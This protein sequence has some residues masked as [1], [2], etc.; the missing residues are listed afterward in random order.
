MAALPS[1]MNGHSHAAMNLLRGY[2]DDMALMDWL[3]NKIWPLEAKLTENDVYWGSKLAFLEMI[4]S[5]TTFFNDMYW[6]FHGTARAAEEMG[7]RGVV[8]AALIDNF[9]K[10]DMQAAK[11]LVQKL[12][13]ESGKYSSRIQYAVAPHAIYTV[14]KDTLIWLRD[15]A[16]EHNLLIH[17]HLSETQNEVEQSLQKF[18]KRPV[19]Y[20]HDLGLLGPNLVVAHAIWLDE[21]ELELLAENNVK[22]VHT[23]ASNMKLCSGIMPLP[24]ILEMN[25]LTCLGTDGTSSNNN[26]D[27][28]EEMKI[29]SLLHK[30]NSRDPQQANAQQVFQLATLNAAKI[31]AIPAGEIAV[32]KLADLILVNLDAVSLVPGFNLISDIVYSANG[33]CV[34]TTI[35]DGKVLMQ[36]RHVEG[37][38]EIIANARKVANDLVKR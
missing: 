37:E 33:S 9:Q 38:E 32:G 14:S 25:I 7:L 8:A 10:K 26:L 4:K 20:L 11:I 31:F 34:D 15:F 5:G 29:A 18:G 21:R 36:N 23:P 16:K 1:L 17:T 22:I 19:E 30:V 13:E 28:I 12:L 24:K 6:H 27:I 2:A 35:C 3:Q